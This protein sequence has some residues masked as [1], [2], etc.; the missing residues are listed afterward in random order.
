MTIRNTIAFLLRCR[1]ALHRSKGL[2]LRRATRAKALAIA[3]FP[4][5]LVGGA[6]AQ[7]TASPS[8][9]QSAQPDIVPQGSSIPGLGTRETGLNGP[10]YL[11]FG[12][13][14]SDLS[15]SQPSW[16]DLYLR[17][18]A[19]TERNSFSAEANRQQRYGE[20]GYFYSLGWTR[21][22]NQDW[23][24]EVSAGT[25]SH[26]GL[27]L[28]KWTFDG[29]VNR[30]LL[31]SRR[32]VVN[33]GWGYDK[34]KLANTDQRYQA[35]AMYYF[36]FNLMAQG[37]VTFTKAQP[38]NILAR[39]QSVAVTYGREKEHYIMG[40][41]E[42]GREGYLI[43]GNNSIYNFPIHN[44]AATYRQWIGVNWGFN[45]SFE[46]D[47]NPYFRRNGAIVAMFLDF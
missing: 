17:G 46:H 25:G 23:Y 20:L 45:V 36:P 16:T 3:L 32:L 21:I 31:S 35:G 9:A 29:I 42:I 10:G 11:E 40:R 38:G 1:P 12:G 34:S 2:K 33:G 39:A 22:I 5:L 28:P 26:G 6:K 19:S 30:K 41:A 24:G 44:Y 7:N 14:R 18:V 8:G 37:G 13:S 47:G 4:A 15:Q 27:F 43:I